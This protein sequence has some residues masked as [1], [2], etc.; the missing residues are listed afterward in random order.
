M[1]GALKESRHN[2]RLRVPASAPA[3]RANETIEAYQDRLVE[4]LKDAQTSIGRLIDVDIEPQFLT[5]V[6]N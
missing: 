2:Y 3:R 6:H 5:A 4:A 1:Q